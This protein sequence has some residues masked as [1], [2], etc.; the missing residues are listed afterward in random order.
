MLTVFEMWRWAATACGLHKMDLGRRRFRGNVRKMSACAHIFLPLSLSFFDFTQQIFEPLLLWSLLLLS[1][2]V[3]LSQNFPLCFVILLTSVFFFSSFP[4]CFPLK[5][6][7]VS[8]WSAALVSIMDTVNL[9]WSEGLDS[10]QC[11]AIL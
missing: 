6:P 9:V 7:G 11:S 4:S 5:T 8:V 2:Q 10:Q 1:L 3:S